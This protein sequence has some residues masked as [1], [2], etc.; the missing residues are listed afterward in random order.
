MFTEEERMTA[1][2]YRAFDA[3]PSVQHI[4]QM[5]KDGLTTAVEMAHALLDVWSHHKRLPQYEGVKFYN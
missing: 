2:A 5:H 1:E 4:L 3:S